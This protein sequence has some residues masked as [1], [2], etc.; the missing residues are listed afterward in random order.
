MKRGLATLSVVAGI[1]GLAAPAAADAPVDRPEAFEVDREQ[2]PPGQAEL[3]FDSGAPVGAWAASVQLGYLD[4]PFRLHTTQ[5]KT[6][7]VERRET[8]ALGGAVTLG[9]R[10]VVDARLPLA[11][12]VGDRM[13][14]LGDERPLDRWVLG[15]LGLGARVRLSSNQ[16]GSV[17]VRGALTLGTGD[18][19][20]FAGEAHFTM[21]WMLIGRL[22]LPHGIVVAATGGVRFRTSEVIVADRLLSDELFGAVGATYELPGLRGLW[23]PENLVRLTGELLGV[24]GNNVGDQ[25]GPSPAE[26]RVGMI[27]EIRPWL[28][29]AGRLGKGLDDHIG[30][31]RLR[32]MLEVVYR[33]A[34]LG[35]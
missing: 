24:L 28:A 12:Q 9:T 26:V 1:A 34:W 30:A 6:F 20:D 23:C 10:L 2:P 18:D 13:Q 25:L 15:D 4:R 31:P 16:R 33:G 7:P 14:G 5:I 32:A 27:S 19:H 11:H 3:G 17:F 22:M 8:L 35:L 21:A 29:V